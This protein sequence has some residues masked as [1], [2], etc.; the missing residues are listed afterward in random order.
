[1]TIVVDAS[2]VVALLVDGG[3][4]GH[5]ARSVLGARALAAPHLMHVEVANILRRSVLARQI[6]DD[7]ASLA[8][9]DLLALPVDLFDY[10]SFA[11]RAWALR[12]SVTLYDAHYVAL[13]EALHAPLVTL[14][15]KLARAP[16]TRCTFLTPP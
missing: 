1:V 13:A 5:W 7:V 9:D 8:H 16:G 12:R 2:V 4:D 15:R 11:A 6:T 3:N 10:A 14:D